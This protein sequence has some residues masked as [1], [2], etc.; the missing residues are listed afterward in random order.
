[1][2][3]GK[4]IL[5]IGTEPWTAPLLSKHHVVL[6]LCKRNKVLY[7]EPFYHLG[8]V[9]RGRG[10]ETLYPEYYHKQHPPSLSKISPI[11]LP[12]SNIIV[13][14]RRLS[15]AI[16]QAQLRA[17]RFQPDVVLTF[18][19]N[20]SFLAKRWDVPFIYYS[21]DYQWDQVAEAKTLAC[22]DLVIAGT[23]KLYHQYQTRTQR[24]EYLPHGVNLSFLTASASET[25]PNLVSLPS[26][27]AGFIGAIND[28][29]DIALLERLAQNSPDLSLILVGPY[30]KNSFGGGLNEA[31]LARLKALSNIHLLG[32]CPSDQL[33]S[34]IGTFDVGL[35][36]YDIKHQRIHFSYH[37][38]LQY[39]C[40]GKPVVTTCFAGSDILP[41]HVTVAENPTSFV[42]AVAQA[43]SHHSSAAA[44]ECRAFA[45]ANT[46]EKRVAQLSEWIQEI[47]D[48]TLHAT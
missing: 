41:P 17:R 18:S 31:K 29:L 39:L 19:P 8:K 26:P 34:Y 44:G 15:E 13:G 12:K 35:I 4:S 32:P 3:T 2:I 33:G 37:K 48:A 30:E 11:L 36:P 24:L 1:M 23:Q 5:V 27:K 38:V 9:L 7:V 16:I 6:E 46:W 10:R 14:V 43:L 28:H 21:V 20:F 40:L 22:A 42:T 47:S 45:D 25:P